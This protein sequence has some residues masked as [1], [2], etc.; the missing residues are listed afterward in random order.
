MPY[1]PRP[2]VADGHKIRWGT[3]SKK[4]RGA[5]CNVGLWKFSRHPNYFGEWMAWNGLALAAIHPLI[6]FESAAWV[7][8]GLLLM[9]IL[10]STNLYYCL[11]EWTGAVPAEYFR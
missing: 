7:K 8:V 5:F 11:S 2:S 4:T 10:I 9:L 3:L 6:R 1:I